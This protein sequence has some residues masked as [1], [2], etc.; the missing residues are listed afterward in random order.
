MKSTRTSPVLTLPPPPT[1]T[2]TAEDTVT[3]NSPH[4]DMTDLTALI[5]SFTD[6]QAA[7][8]ATTMKLMTDSAAQAQAIKEMAKAVATMASAPPPT[9]ANS[10]T[11]SNLSQ[12]DDELAELASLMSNDVDIVRESLDNSNNE[13]HFPDS[14]CLNKVTTRSISAT[15]LDGTTKTIA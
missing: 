5:K 13:E 11:T 9:A 12:N 6:A 14:P 1:S 2:T 10:T 15:I 3:T 8:Q 4:I 7:S